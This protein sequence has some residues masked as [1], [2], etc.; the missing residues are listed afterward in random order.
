MHALT[1]YMRLI[2][3]LA[4]PKIGYLYYPNWNIAIILFLVIPFAEVLSIELS[5]IGSSRA[6]D[7]RS[8]NQ[9]GGFM[10]I[11]FMIIYV[12][13]EIGLIVLN[14]TNLLIIAGTLL[15]IDI[16]LFFVSTATFRR[17]EILTK[18]K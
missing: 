13:S 10:F 2:D 17:E 7:V 18:W 11:P 5:V 12:G 16:G 6:S 8:A 14:N 3:Y 9:L 1:I 4:Y 15:I